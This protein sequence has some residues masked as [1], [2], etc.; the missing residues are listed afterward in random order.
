[1]KRTLLFKIIISSLLVLI[2]KENI[3]QS[4][5]VEIKY[6]LIEKNITNLKLFS[7][8]KFQNTTKAKKSLIKLKQKL[9]LKGYIEVSI[10][11][12]VLKGNIL[13]SYLYIGKQ[14]KVAKLQNGNLSEAQLQKIHF[15]PEEYEN[16][17]YS[18]RKIENLQQKALSSFEN[19]GYPFAEVFLDSF[20][21]NK[22]SIQ[23]KLFAN[24]NE[25]FTFDSLVVHGKTKTTSNFLEHYL[26]IKKGELYDY[27]KIKSI[28]SKL[29]QLSYIKEY[30]ETQ[31]VFIEGKATV[32]IF[33]EKQKSNE[34]N[35][36]LGIL[37]NDKLT[38][39]S[40]TITGDGRLNLFNSF[41]V[42]E[43][44]FV[45]FKQ[46][47]PKTQNLDFKFNYPYFINLPFGLSGTFNLYKNDTAFLNLNTKVGVSYPFNGADFIQ[48]FYRNN[49]SNILNQDTT[50][51]RT[52]K[53]LPNLLDKTNNLIGLKLHFQNLDYIFN[54]TK[55]YLFTISAAVGTRTIR[56]NS[57]LTNIESTIYKSVEL[58]SINYN[59]GLDL[60]Y[61]LTIYKK[62]SIVLSNKS[63]F[64]ISKN[65]LENEKMRIG[66]AKSLR[67]FDEEEIYTPY[68]SIFTAEY[69]FS[70]S[71][72]AYFYTFGDV[73]IVEDQRFGSKNI[74][75]PF[76]F[77]VGTTFETKGGIF[78]LSYALGK[79]FNNPIEI[80][81]GKIHFGYINLF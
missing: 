5:T 9:Q 4:N 33:L 26:N 53:Q 17:S 51:V 6:H 8:N 12:I 65:V 52:T 77:G 42:G 59:V 23:A 11:S 79:Q 27:S 64:F 16:Q 58:E 50:G 15:K 34:F 40:V 73:S 66:G 44:V 60:N 80:K 63:K 32:N 28:S 2:T 78:S 74:D 14:Y 22:Y 37:P 81:N 71:K 76:G 47:K 39:R 48:V 21:I 29:K 72:N 68:F 24:K 3:A 38:D 10:D 56:Q 54:P 18:F 75:I 31:I 69:H 30:R 43:E 41:G 67:G 57:K 35:L 55:G 1:M 45:D 49:I 70:L 20:S 46:L 7:K 62:H 19:N 61:Y 13:H 25:L 36:L